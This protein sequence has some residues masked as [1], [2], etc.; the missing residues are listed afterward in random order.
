MNFLRRWTISNHLFYALKIGI[1]SAISIYLAELLQLEYS[2]SAGIITLLTI[3]GTKTETFRLGINRIATFFATVALCWLTHLLVGPEW[4]GYGIVMV[5]VTFFLSMRN[6]LTTLSVN[7]VFVSHFL[8]NPEQK[9]TS[10]LILNELMLLMIGLLIAVLVNHFQNYE[11][12][13]RYL[14]Q[15]AAVTEAKLRSIFMK[16][17]EY[18]KDPQV[19]NHVWEE[20]IQLEKDI[21][22]YTKSAFQ[23]QQNRLPLMDNYYVDYFEMR[24]QQCSVLHNL[25]YE[26][27]KIRVFQSDSQVVARFLDDIMDHLPEMDAP[28][29][30]LAKLDQLIQQ[31][32]EENLPSSREEFLSKARLYHILM[33][34][35]EFLKFKKR[36]VAGLPVGEEPQRQPL[37]S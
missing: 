21:L 2:S 31:I 4:I 23:Y 29:S 19:N 24:L 12:Q 22:L 5:I 28:E 30:Q 13:K 33:D 3:S 9:I 15:S 35:E 14:D 8:R 37:Q 25:H 36:F 7:A 17:S 32:Q 11:S 18:L 16:L 20:I 26:M 10:E 34:L 27:K 6:L 1:G